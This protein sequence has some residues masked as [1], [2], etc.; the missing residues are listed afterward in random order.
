MDKSRSGTL[1][2]EELKSGLEEVYGGLSATADWSELVEKMDIDGTGGIN[3]SE[4]ILAASSSQKLI[5][6]EN[7]NIAF[8]MFDIDGNNMITLNE[9][10]QVFDTSNLGSKEEEKEIWD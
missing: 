6:D 9:L 10:K 2:K 5:T 1:S 8:K 4:F 3:F 7:L